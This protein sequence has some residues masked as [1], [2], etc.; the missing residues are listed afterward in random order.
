MVVQIV[1]PPPKEARKSD[2][3]ASLLAAPGYKLDPVTAVHIAAMRQKYRKRFGTDGLAAQIMARLPTPH[4]KQLEIEMS[5]AKR[6][7][8]NAGRRVGKTTLAARVAVI[9]MCEGRRVL[10]S[11]TSQ[12][13]ADSFW[14]K[15]KEWLQPF[16]DSGEIIK[17]ETKHTLYMPASHGRIKAKTASDADQLR[18][19][20]ADLLVLDEC[21]RLEE[22]AWTKV[23]A[24][25]LLDNNGEA[26]FISTPN[27][28]NWFF[29]MFNEAEEDKSGRMEA[30][31]FSSFEN[32]YLSQEALDEII[33]DLDDDGYRQEIMA[34]FLEGEGQVFRNIAACMHAPRTEPGDHVGHFMVMG[35]DWGQRKDYTVLSVFC[36]TCGYEV[37]IERFNQIGWAI[38]RDRLDFMY[39]KWGVRKA[40]LEFNSIGG[41]NLEALRDEKHLNVEGFE[42]DSTNKGPLVRAFNLMLEKQRGQWQPNKVGIH[43]LE[44]YEGT[45]SP[46]TLHTSYSA[47][48][49]GHDDT[50][51]ARML[52]WKAAQDGLGPQAPMAVLYSE[53]TGVIDEGDTDGLDDVF[54]SGTL[55]YSTPHMGNDY[56]LAG[57]RLTSRDY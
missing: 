49:G 55:P 20:N 7:V 14:E 2:I 3:A 54:G 1:A 46:K 52:V 50:V 24:P 5:Q 12:D 15:C 38:Q 13:Q 42:T 4:P 40:L 48:K 51:M 8:V 26:W 43:E 17:N 34:E 33:K 19:D 45:T 41:P 31:K 25:M 23:G 10:L 29:R 30:W 47:P 39:H 36:A 44:A 21:S 56:A 37:E 6:K 22:E 57:L 16:I 53:A 32:P 18:G 9:K 11:S 35:G 28:R 27:R